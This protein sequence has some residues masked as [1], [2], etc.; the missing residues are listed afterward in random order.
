M[1]QALAFSF[2]QPAAG[3][4]RFLDSVAVFH[5]FNKTKTIMKNILF[6]SAIFFAVQTNAQNYQITFKGTGESETINTVNVE[7]LTKGTSLTMSGSDILS[8]TNATVVNFIKN[9]Q[10]SDITIYPNPATDNSIMQI[11]PPVSGNANIS[12]FDM[13]GRP[14]TQIQSYLGNFRQDFRLSGI[15]N[16][17]YIIN[18]KGNSYLL[19]GKLLGIGKS[20]GTISIV[21]INNNIQ[22]IDEKTS[23]TDIKGVQVTVDMDYSDG[24]RLKFTGISGIFSTVMTDIPVSDKI[25]TFNFI[26]CKDGDNNNYPTVQIGTQVWMAENLRTT[27]FNDNSIIP[28]VAN[29][30]DWI[31]LTT[32]GYC[33][34]NNDEATYK[35]AYG[36]LYNQ[37]TVSTG[38]LCPAGWHVPKDT[39]WT[40]FEDYLIANGY[41]YDGTTEI[42]KVA[43]S[44]ASSTGWTSSANTGSV[45]NN[46]Y[47]AKRNATGFT[48]LP[49]GLRDYMGF[50][51][52]GSNGYW[53]SATAQDE[54]TYLFRNMRYDLPDIGGGADNKEDGLSVRCLQDI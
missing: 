11:C 43:K 17:F 9:N 29:D 3:R 49:G 24:D 16:G 41:N 4:K 7:N 35:A 34:Y 47:P 37:Y 23:E 52:A 8:L 48:A 53:W 1:D 15:K 6:V 20:Y 12:V 44:L 46:D 40:T 27:S 54:W 45:G 51:E 28:L 18:V 42:N 38:N 26:A 2:S 21:R 31:A 13:T 32:P 50:R 14:I 33:W 10:L 39:D 5:I 22:T 25:I 30:D 36:A 19:S